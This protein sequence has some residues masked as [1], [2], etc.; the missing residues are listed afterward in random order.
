MTR[1]YLSQCWSWYMSPYGVIRPQWVNLYMFFVIK[2]SDWHKADSWLS[3]SKDIKLKK[4]DFLQNILACKGLTLLGWGINF[5][6]DFTLTID[7]IH[8]SH[9]AFVSSHNAP[10]RTEICTFLFRMVNCGIWNR[11]IVRFVILAYSNLIKMIHLFHW[12]SI[13]V[14]NLP[15][16]F[17]LTIIKI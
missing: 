8:K 2:I 17:V 3:F 15:Q 5:T 12:D 7:L 1:H 9:N 16:I 11:C 6:K 14:N 13:R 4:G 10:F